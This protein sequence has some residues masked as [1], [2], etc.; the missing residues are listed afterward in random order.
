MPTLRR[1]LAA[2]G[3]GRSSGGRRLARRRRRARPAARPAGR[4]LGRR[5]W[6]A[7]PARRPARTPNQRRRA[8]PAQRAPRRLARRGRRPHGR[9]HGAARHAGPGPAPPRLHAQRGR[10]QP[11]RRRVTDPTAASPT[12]RRACCA[13][14]G[15]DVFRDDP[16]RLLRLPRIAAEL[17]FAVE[18]TT[19]DSL[20]RDADL[21][22]ASRRRA[23][24]R[25]AAA[26][27]SPCATRPTR[28]MLAD[29]LGVLAAVLPEVDALHDV[30]QSLPPPRRLPPHAARHRLDRRRRRQRRPLLPRPRRG[31]RHRG[32]AR[33]ARSTPP[34]TCAPACAG[35]ALFTTSRSRTR[36]R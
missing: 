33:H 8:V 16:L 22:A 26:A 27:S 21:V 36:A 17:E 35:R 2:R 12:S 13:P 5:S 29:R 1:E 4:R 34:S 11:R 10:R 15:D 31:G 9:L 7:T 30:E 32:V 6:R 23:P 25:R 14:V 3:R 24:A 20:R 19:A 28:C 18:Q